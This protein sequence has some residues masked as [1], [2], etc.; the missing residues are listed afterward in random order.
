MALKS[1]HID[2]PLEAAWE[3]LA[4]GWRYSDWVVGSRTPGSRGRGGDGR[5]T[6]RAKP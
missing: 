6:V 4:D 2:A 5:Q 1:T 3:A